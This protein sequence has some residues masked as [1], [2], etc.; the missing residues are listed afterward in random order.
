MRERTKT[1]L[2]G[3]FALTVA[4]AILITLAGCDNL[5][6]PT[7]KPQTG[8][9]IAAPGSASGPAK[10]IPLPDRTPRAGRTLVF[11]RA[12]FKYGFGRNYLRQWLDRPLFQDRAMRVVEP[13]IVMPLA[14]LEKIMRTAGSYEVDGLAFFPETSLRAPILEASDK[15]AVPGFQ[16]LPEFTAWSDLK[17]KRN[18]LERALAGKSAVRLD[19]KLL[20]TSY[21]TGSWPPEKWKNALAE[22]RAGLDGDFLFLVQLNA[23]GGKGWLQ[24]CGEYNQKGSLSAQDMESIKATLRAYLDVCDGIMPISSNMI[25]YRNNFDA[26]FYRE[27]VIPSLR[28]VLD[29]PQ[30]RNKLLGLSVGLGYFAPESGSTCDERGTKTLREAF[31]AA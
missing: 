24:W 1:G 19:G 16:L 12:Q 25:K 6:C 17:V 22:L 28:S 9:G 21:G 8:P 2:C 15:L 5:T 3:N 13:G 4:A 10:M 30:Y 7:T 26:R 14:T 11:P 18:I 20:I 31:Q 23:A 29:E 27:I